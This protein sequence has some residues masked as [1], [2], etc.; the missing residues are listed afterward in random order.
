MRE[1]LKRRA[2]SIEEVGKANLNEVGSGLASDFER[3]GKATKDIASDSLHAVTD[4]LGGIYKQG[5]K[6]VMQTKGQLENRIRSHPVQTL[7]IAA[8]AGFIIGWLNRKS[9]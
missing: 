8:G 1:Q 7:L 6:K 9:K 5:K 4:E 2:E 3:L